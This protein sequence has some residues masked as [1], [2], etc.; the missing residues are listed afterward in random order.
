MA[1]SASALKRVRQIVVRTSRNRVVKNNVKEARKALLVAVEGGNKD[2]AAKAL[3]AVS[4][5]ADRAAKKNII[6]RNTAGNIKAKA[7][8]RVKAMA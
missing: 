6:H 4:S 2:E 1:N 5:T 8:A 7:A 3:V